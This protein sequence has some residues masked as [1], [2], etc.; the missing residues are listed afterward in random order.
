MA[1]SSP[2]LPLLRAQPVGHQARLSRHSSPPGSAESFSTAPRHA[3]LPADPTPIP[4][5]NPLLSAPARPQGPP[6]CHVA[7]R[8]LL[9]LS[10]AVP[11]RSPPPHREAGVPSIPGLHARATQRERGRG[12]RTFDHSYSKGRDSSLWV[13]DTKL[14]LAE[15][16]TAPLFSTVVGWEGSPPFDCTSAKGAGASVHPPFLS[17]KLQCLP[18]CWKERCL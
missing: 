9:L 8:R 12:V 13:A 1:P 18:R 17:L 2:F 4:P 10:P 14:H 5:V 6:G 3:S 7:V 16:F 15:S 11:I